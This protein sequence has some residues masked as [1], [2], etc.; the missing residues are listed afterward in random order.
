LGSKFVP[1][2]RLAL[3]VAAD[4]RAWA[5]FLYCLILRLRFSRLQKERLMRSLLSRMAICGALVPSAG[6]IGCTANIHDNTVSIP[7]ATVNMTS[8]ADTS[9]VKPSEAVPVE[10]KVDN[11]VLVEPSATPPPDKM[12]EA[13]HL[14]IHM[15]SEDSPAILITAQTSFTVTIPPD[16]KPGDHNLIC[17]VHKH[18]GTATSAESELKVTVKSM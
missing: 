6:L 8:S 15:D 16:A 2:P 4:D 18:D 12:N 5:R 9:N 11:V 13:G 3:I 7:N 10:V 1:Y 17:R 14:E